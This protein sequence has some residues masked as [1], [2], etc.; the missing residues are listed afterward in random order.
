MRCVVG[1]YLLLFLQSV[2]ATECRVNGVGG[3]GP[4]EN[5]RGA[6]IWLR[7]NLQL[8]SATGRVV[9]T[10]YVL[11]CRHRFEWGLPA[12]AEDYID[13][14]ANAF[15]PQTAIS[16]L[17]S[18]LAIRVV[19]YVR[20]VNRG[21]RL[22][23]LHVAPNSNIVNLQTYI[24]FLT[25]G[26][27]SYVH[28]PEGSFLGSIRLDVTSRDSSRPPFY[29][30][31]HVFANNTLNLNPLTC[32]INNNQPITVDFDQVDPGAIGLTPG[33]SSIKMDQAFNYSCP[34][35]GINSAISITFR[36]PSASFNPNYLAVD[37]VDLGI[38]MLRGGTVVRPQGAF[39]TS[40]SNSYGSDNVT[41]ALIRRPGAYPDPGPFSGSATLVM[42]VP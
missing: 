10:G 1:L 37:N 14:A 32:V 15:T 9:A 2:I 4:W 16:G 12:N 24:Y 26:A 25:Q 7:A 22:A 35:A 36:G 39:T 29:F 42:G 18:G 38:G 30:L 21:I 17:I 28:V 33:A 13:T 20:P 31:V 6:N 11:E 41:F 23:S 27:S 40:L 5:V 8:D 34:S 19:D 3:V